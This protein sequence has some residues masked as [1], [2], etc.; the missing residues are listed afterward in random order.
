M[1]ACPSDRFSKPLVPNYSDDQRESGKRKE[2]RHTYDP[3]ALTTLGNHVRT[4]HR[5]YR[6]QN[7]KYQWKNNP[8]I[9]KKL[10][11][12]TVGF[13]NR[14]INVAEPICSGDCKEQNG[15]S[16]ADAFR[17]G[18]ATNLHRTILPDSKRLSS[19][20]AQWPVWVV[21]RNHTANQAIDSVRPD[22][23]V[24]HW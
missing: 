9:L 13:D 7:R 4:S 12:Q 8:V 17:V 18:H 23:D 14:W 2:R 15:N 22:A 5:K 16:N 11:T 21:S 20:S 1:N 6:T 24:R 19:R 10:G 3:S